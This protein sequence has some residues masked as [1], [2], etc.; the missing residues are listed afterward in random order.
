MEVYDVIIIGAGP[1]G[2][3]A[4]IYTL[5]GHLKTLILEKD[6]PGGKIVRTSEITNWP[7]SNF[8]EGSTLAYNMFEQVLSLNAVYKYGNVLKILSKKDYHVVITDDAKYK[9]KAIIIATGTKYRSL[10]LPNESKFYGN[11]ISFCAICDAKLYENKPIAI[12][13]GGD[14][15]LK[16]AL[17]LSKFASEVYLIHR[18]NEFRGSDIF[19]K[20]ILKTSNI[21][22]KTPCEVIALEGENHLDSIK[23]VDKDKNEVSYL[24]ISGL[25]SFIGSDP[26]TGFV[27]DLLNLNPQGYIK[28]NQ[29]METNVENIYAVGD[30]IEKNLKQII[31]ACNDGAIAG[32]HLVE[33]NII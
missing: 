23:I 17:Y 30:V 25:F 20:K 19:L 22:I 13:G 32:Q 8:I 27:K 9:A 24:Y 16:E 26:A 6:T 12:V 28:V 4:A 10:G 5:R 31:T 29:N 3:S 33:K 15:A 2:L 14:S 1:A 18:R 7:G 11:G 21:T